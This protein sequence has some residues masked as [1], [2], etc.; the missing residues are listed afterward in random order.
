DSAADDRDARCAAW[1][2][3]RRGKR[4]HGPAERCGADSGAG[5]LQEVAPGQAHLAPFFLHGLHGAAR[6]F[7]LIEIFEEGLEL[8]EH[9]SAGHRC[10]LEKRGLWKSPPTLIDAVLRKQVVNS[11]S[12]GAI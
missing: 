10:L 5:H 6:P 4:R 11:E 2:R 1:L 3:P 7:G 12:P 8:P 9:R